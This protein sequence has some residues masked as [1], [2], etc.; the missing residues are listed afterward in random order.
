MLCDSSSEPAGPAPG[1]GEVEKIRAIGLP[2]RL[3]A[4][5]LDAADY[6]FHGYTTPCKLRLIPPV[7]PA[8]AAELRAAIH[9]WRGRPGAACMAALVALAGRRASA[10]AT[11]NTAGTPARGVKSGGARSQSGKRGIA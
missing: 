1:G 9:P 3:W 5:A 10:T 4:R 6:A 11:T 8:P 7:V 2:N